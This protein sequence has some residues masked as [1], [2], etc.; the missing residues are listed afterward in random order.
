MTKYDPAIQPSSLT[1]HALFHKISEAQQRYQL[2]PTPATHTSLTVVVGVSGG[3]DSTCLLHVLAQLAEP[4]RLNLHVAHVDHNLRPESGADALFVATVAADLQLPFHSIQLPV[5][6]LAHQP[7]GLEAAARRARYAFLTQVAINVTPA[8]QVPVLVLAHHADDQAETVLLH[9]VRGSGLQGLGGIRWLNQ[10]TVEDFGEQANH[11]EAGSKTRTIQVVRPLLNVQRSEILAYLTA[12][13]L[14]WRED[15][16]NQETRLLRNQMRHEIM[17]VLTQINSNLVATLGRTAQILAAEAE[18]LQKIDRALLMSLAEVMPTRRVVLDLPK[19]SALDLASQ[20]GVLR[21]ALVT[22]QTDLQDVEFGP[23]ER[24]L[25]AVRDQS[26]AGGPYSLLHAIAWS[27]AGATAN[28]P[29]RLSLH[30][31]QVLP[32]LPDH[33]YLDEDW[34]QQIGRTP[35]LLTGTFAEPDGWSLQMEEVSMQAVL[36]AL[37]GRDQAWQAYLD[38]AQV[39]APMLTTPQPGLRF[40][41]LGMHGHHQLLGDFFTN[42]KVPS[43]LRSGWPLII[44]QSNGEVLWV[45]GLQLAHTACITLQTSRVLSLQWSKP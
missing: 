4:W 33:P 3:A 21:Q 41:P 36:S 27:V 7:G 37:P 32:F 26:P 45:C 5:N 35:L 9:L 17:P 2:F 10:W 15:S 8:A 44:D 40:A 13:D 6:S 43:S 14:H 22:L 18:R 29:A 1:A 23:L 11:R 16:S 25:W 19:F 12:H 30:Q 31:A 24:L 20:R 28:R 38:A 39:D 42:R 34:R